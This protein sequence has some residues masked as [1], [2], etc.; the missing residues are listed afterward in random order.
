M[1]TTSS[2]NRPQS[3][4][5]KGVNHVKL[6]VHSIQ[7]SLHF[8]TNVLPFTHLKQFDHFT[9]EHKLF[10]SMFI[11]E[12]TKFLM[13]VRYHPEQAEAQKG[14]DPV[15]FGVGTRK[16]LEEWSSWFDECGVVH[17]PILVGI[18]GWLMCAEDPDGKIVRLYVEDEEHEW[19]DHPDISEKWLGTPVGDPSA[20]N[21]S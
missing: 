16:D 14:W 3:L 7:R 19:T 12:P 11:Y 20:D 21:D 9:P 2:D 1:S 5:F 17:S 8:Y 6:A 10:G 13:E 18:K 15:T 4:S